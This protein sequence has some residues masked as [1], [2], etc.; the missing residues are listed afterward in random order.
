M[1]EVLSETPAPKA[2]VYIIPPTWPPENPKPQKPIL[3]R[4]PEPPGLIR[5]NAEKDS[6]KANDTPERLGE[7]KA[8]ETEEI[9]E[10]VLSD[11][12][13]L[14]ESVSISTA[15]NLTDDSGVHHGGHVG[16]HRSPA[17]IRASRMRSF[18][19][20]MATRRD[21]TAQSQTRRSDQSPRR[22]NAGPVRPEPSRSRSA[23]RR[24][25][26]D[27]RERSAMRSRSPAMTRVENL[28]P[29][30]TRS[31]VGRSPSARRTNPS[32]GR[33]RGDPNERRSRDL[34]GNGG[35]QGNLVSSG[36]QQ[37]VNGGESLD[38]ENPLVSLECFI[39]L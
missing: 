6:V 16:D 20:D 23:P 19:G 34:D 5:Q 12:C 14:S 3:D 1:K 22:R 37:P 32:P 38:L 13:S 39:F 9:S 31:V 15:T 10:E 21:Q 29:G 35:G 28:G 8:K 26:R 25:D 4:V 30:G 2:P 18:S 24:Q 36:N 7:L 33:F 11:I 27:P 17:K